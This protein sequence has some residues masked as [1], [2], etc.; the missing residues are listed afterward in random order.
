M[1]FA[2]WLTPPSST[3]AFSCWLIIPGFAF[4]WVLLLNMMDVAKSQGK[5]IDTNGI[6]KSLG[7][8]VV[9]LVAAD[10]KT[11]WHTFSVC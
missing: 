9:P 7:I 10:K 8:P 3:A 2:Y 5:Q 4:P 11:V 1:L 6:A